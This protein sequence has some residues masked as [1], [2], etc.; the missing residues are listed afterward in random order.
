MKV[1]GDGNCFI[2]AVAFN[3]LWSKQATDYD[4]LFFKTIDHNT[5]KK[6]KFIK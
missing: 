6:I 1:R 4:T 2:R 3:Y 5:L